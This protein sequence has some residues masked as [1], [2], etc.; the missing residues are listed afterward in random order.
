MGALAHG[1]RGDTNVESAGPAAATNAAEERRTEGLSGRQLAPFL[2]FDGARPLP[3]IASVLLIRGDHGW[4]NG[5]GTTSHRRRRFV[6]WRIPGRVGGRASVSSGLADLLARNA[7]RLRR[8]ATES[9]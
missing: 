9:S 6:L 8:K 4:T 5:N 2:S 3:W 7:E 1:D